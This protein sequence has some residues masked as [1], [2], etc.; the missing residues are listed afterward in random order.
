MFSLRPSGQLALRTSYI[1]ATLP[2]KEDEN[3]ADTDA[4]PT[5]PTEDDPWN[6]MVPFDPSSEVDDVF[7]A[8]EIPMAKKRRRRTARVSLQCYMK[9]IL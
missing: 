9:I 2:E 8:P 7:G 3:A 4:G 5:I 1:P 6:E